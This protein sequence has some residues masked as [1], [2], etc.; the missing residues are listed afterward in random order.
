MYAH[1]LA[2]AMPHERRQMTNPDT[3]PAGTNA[4]GIIGEI[5]EDPE[6]DN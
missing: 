1:V 6:Q 2:V 5:V 3:K 4:L